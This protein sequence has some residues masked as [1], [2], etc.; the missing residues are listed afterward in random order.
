VKA[1][2]LIVQGENDL[3]VSVE[4]ARL[5]AAAKP[6]ARL[7]IVPGMNHVLKAAPADRAG[8]LAA[9]AEPDRPLAPGLMGA[10]LGFV[11]A[12]AAP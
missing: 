12:S 11:K 6:D 1:P 10:I 4:D 8:N 7:V 3:Q 2:V 5:L 9:Y